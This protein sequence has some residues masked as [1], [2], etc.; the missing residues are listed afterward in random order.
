MAGNAVR[1]WSSSCTS[2]ESLWR[3]FQTSV[4]FWSF[5]RGFA[6]IL[7]STCIDTI[8]AWYTF[9]AHLQ[10]CLL[11]LVYSVHG[12]HDFMCFRIPCAQTSCG[13]LTNLGQRACQNSQNLFLQVEEI[14]EGAYL[15]CRSRSYLSF[16]AP[17]FTKCDI[18][19][20][21]Q[22]NWKKWAWR[23]AKLIVL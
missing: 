17:C 18:S 8:Q 23:I 9:S 22:R 14:V 13:R 5:V 12:T 16:T 7:G 15:P 6:V 1:F 19:A 11:C 21:R 2:A 4:Q 10:I 20:A 3:V